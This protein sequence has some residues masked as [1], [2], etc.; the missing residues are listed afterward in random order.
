MAQVAQFCF[1]YLQTYKLIMEKEELKVAFIPM[2]E[3]EYKTYL[4]LVFINLVVIAVVVLKMFFPMMYKDD[5]LYSYYLPWI[6][7]FT[8]F[9]I[10]IFIKLLKLSK[11][12]VKR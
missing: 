10:F 3:R 6:M 7:F 8:F 1:S 12:K 11:T 4:T 2:N 9:H 5:W